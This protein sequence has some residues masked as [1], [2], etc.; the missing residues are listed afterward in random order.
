MNLPKYPRTPSEMWADSA[1]LIHV[2]ILT[3][4]KE[5]AQVLLSNIGMELLGYCVH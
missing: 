1:H 3:R 2:A 4:L 5:G